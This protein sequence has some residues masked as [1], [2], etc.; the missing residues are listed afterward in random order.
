MADHGKV[1][2][3]E[4]MTRDPEAAAVFYGKLFGWTPHRVAMADPSRPAE[5]DEPAY[6]LFM[7][8]G[9]PACGAFDISGPNHEGMPSMWFTYVSVDDVDAA[10]EEAGRN[11]GEVL[12]PPFDVPKVGRIAMIRDAEGTMIGLGTPA[13]ER[14][15]A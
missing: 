9:E 6:T 8:D 11:G 2:W 14:G 3:T 15:G 12:Q 7:K 10:V 4:L 5:P 1:W 13:A